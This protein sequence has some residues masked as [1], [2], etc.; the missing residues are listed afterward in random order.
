[1]STNSAARPTYSISTEWVV[2]F[3]GGNI[4]QGLQ[5]FL[6]NSPKELLTPEECENTRMQCVVAVLDQVEWLRE[7]FADEV[8]DDEKRL[9][10]WLKQLPYDR[11]R[12][13]FHRH[14]PAV[15]VR[16]IGRVPVN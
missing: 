3:L 15:L 16:G 12:I 13:T 11:R 14:E 8:F 10:E 9:Q 6:S 7:P 5:A 4:S 2:R 1:M